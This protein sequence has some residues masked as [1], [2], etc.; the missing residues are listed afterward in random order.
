METF[1]YLNDPIYF[2]IPRW[3][4]V[5]CRAYVSKFIGGPTESTEPTDSRRFILKWV[6]IIRGKY[7]HMRYEID[8]N[9]ELAFCSC[10]RNR[11]VQI[12]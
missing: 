5:D 11:S 2:E 12:Y 4:R 3:G 8:S 7:T 9:G 10:K 6:H 1:E